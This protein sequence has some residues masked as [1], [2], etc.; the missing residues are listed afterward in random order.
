MVQRMAEYSHPSHFIL[1]FSDTHLIAGDKNLYGGVDATAHLERIFA[2]VIESGI[3][4]EALVFTG[5]IV[6]TGQ[7][8]AYR[9]IRMMAET[10]A[11]ILGAKLIWVMGNH[12]EVSTFRKE[13]LDDE[14]SQGPVD[15]VYDLNG[16]RM[17]VLDTTVPG[18]H[19]GEI[20]TEQL[21]WLEE[22][23]AIP[24][25]H[26]SMLALHHPPIPAV[27]QSAVTVELRDQKNLAEVI[28]GSD[29]RG[30]IG[31]HLHYSC[32]GT[33]AGIPV[34][35]ASSTCYTQDLLVK[36]GGT[37]GRDGAQ[38]FNMIHVYGDTI[39]HSVVPAGKGQLVGKFISPEESAS[40]L[41]Q[42]GIVIPEA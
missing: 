42:E 41:L 11:K 37:Y 2:E 30:I 7:A 8:E 1:H 33:F 18:H 28:Q 5:D 13:L 10:T 14:T 15:A 3:R 17:I 38:G 16:L 9:K 35:V 27:I 25:P 12:D 24:S 21:Q 39:L 4:P 20:S 32:F 31:G 29:I 26:G 19:Y 23:L 34:S 22:V 36:E 40:I 6:D